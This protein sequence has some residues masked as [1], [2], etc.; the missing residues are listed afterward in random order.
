MSLL[1]AWRK[2]L[3]HDLMT[4]APLVKEGHSIHP[5]GGGAVKRP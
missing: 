1:D 5:I 2:Q 3:K 4:F